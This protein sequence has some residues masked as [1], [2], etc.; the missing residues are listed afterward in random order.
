MN[1]PKTSVFFSGY[2][3]PQLWDGY[4]PLNNTTYKSSK[5][6]F[7]EKH[8]AL[9]L[10]IINIYIRS[11]IKTFI[12]GGTQ[13]FDLM[14][15]ELILSLRKYNDIS[16]IIAKPFP[17][18]GVQWTT[19]LKEHFENICEKADSTI[20]VSLGIYSPK[21]MA[22][23]NQWMIDNADYGLIMWDEKHTG[24]IFS[25]MKYSKKC[26]KTIIVINPDTLQL[27]TLVV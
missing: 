2:R 21:K 13:G 15:A 24:E 14:C 27:S 5:Q 22:L 20:N 8:V 7:H 6:H 16:L 11:G 10:Q 23:R 4:P 1:N 9:M 3:S 18:H 12:V 17:D 19:N 25:C 26:N